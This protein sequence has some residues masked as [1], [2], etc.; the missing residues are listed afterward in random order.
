MKKATIASLLV[1][2]AILSPGMISRNGT[3]FSQAATGGGVQ[4]DPAEFADYDNAATKLASDPKAQAAAF[5]A[6][7][8]KYPK[9]AVKAN[10]QQSLMID[11]Y[12]FDHAKAIDAADKV[13][14]VAPNN[15]QALTIEA[16][17]RTEA[18][19]ALTDPAA[20][21]SALDTAASYAQK[22]LDAPKPEG[23]SDADFA[24]LKSQVTPSFYSTIGADDLGKKD[25]AGAIAAFKAEL[26]AVPLAS[27]T[28]VGTPLQDTYYLGV[29]YYS[30][31]TPDLVNCT[32]YTTRAASY[33]PDTYKAQFQ[34]LATYCYKKFHGGTDGYDA[35]VTS[36]KANLFMPDDLKIV[37][38]PTNEDIIKKTFSDT[39]DPA[40]LALP[41]KEF[42][43]Q[44]GTAADADKIFD[45]IKGKTVQI[46]G[47]VIV[48]ATAD[49]LQVAVSEDAVQASPK[50]ADFTFNMKTPFKTVPAVGDKI[51]LTGTYA[52][53]TQKP[54]MITMSDGDIV[55]KKTPVKAPAKKPAAGR[56]PR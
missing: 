32:F 50:V 35:V 42:I 37:P 1:I 15:F 52:S 43:I 51:D 3:A 21:Q 54:L 8:V 25:S 39:P 47:A 12:Q 18:A 14:Q 44:N 7:L 38:A 22:G 34:P 45:A 29:A 33:A 53:Y 23:T 27:T 46:P 28:A 17:F 13:L 56:R 10:V 9:S 16:V 40:T 19:Q 4:M 36:A 2:P 20:K 11:Y 48:A 55:A 30:S 24:K 6:Y 49:Q 5:E 41:D 31:A 26:A